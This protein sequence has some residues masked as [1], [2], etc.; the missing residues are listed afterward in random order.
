[1]P[2]YLLL[3]ASWGAAQGGEST[4]ARPRTFDLRPGV[5]YEEY[6]G[7][8][9]TRSGRT[10]TTGEFTAHVPGAVWIRG[11][12]GSAKRSVA[13]ATLNT[14]FEANGVSAQHARWR[15]TRLTGELCW[16][17]PLVGPGFGL[18]VGGS[19]TYFIDGL[20]QFLR[21]N[22]KLSGSAALHVEQTL[23]FGPSV[24]IGLNVV[25]PKVQVQPVFVA[26]H[27]RPVAAT[28]MWDDGLRDVV[29]D[30]YGIR[31]PVGFVRPI[32]SYEGRVGVAVR[33]ISAEVVYR[34]EDHA[35]SAYDQAA[36]D[37]VRAPGDRVPYHQYVP[38][39]GIRVGVRLGAAGGASD[40]GSA[41]D[42][43]AEGIQSIGVEELDAVFAQVE[44]IR[45]E[46]E[47]LH[48]KL[49]EA[50]RAID[51][52]AKE[53]GASSATEFI[54]GINRGDVRVG[55]RI[56]L[57]GGKPKVLPTAAVTGEVAQVVEAFDALSQAVTSVQSSVPSMAKSAK[58]LVEE[59]QELIKSGPEVIR[60]ARI[61]PSKIPTALKALKNNIAV[62]AAVPAELSTTLSAAVKL[63]K[64]LIPAGAPP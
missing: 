5:T 50:Y 59:T 6:T 1:M 28:T 51:R 19:G 32:T 54:A 57:E 45:R 31:L 41:A 23:T 26:A 29:E 8:D 34:V 12:A 39:F 64:L 44:A 35:I 2:P 53:L 40:D 42:E 37:A 13:T 10:F 9:G 62:T 48:A 11:T 25:T 17:T 52:L 18:R 7:V 24:A 60:K 33:K 22:Q 49:S 56:V 27:E 43:P 58:R 55:V 14:L 36:N 20:G 30:S 38:A 4:P 15:D 3:F 21:T 47:A 63:A 16:E 46:R 61:P